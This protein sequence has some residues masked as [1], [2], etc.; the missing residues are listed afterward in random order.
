MAWLHSGWFA[1]VCV[2][3]LFWILYEGL[4]DFLYHVL[5][6]QVFSKGYGD[7]RMISLTFDDGPD[8]RYTPQVLALLKENDAKATFFLVGK[9]AKAYPDLVREIVKQGHE[10]AVHGYHHTHAWILSPWKTVREFRDTSKVLQE[11]TGQTPKYYRP[12]WGMFNLC[13]R[14]AGK[15]IGALPVL[16]NVTA[17][18]WRAGDQVD[19]IKKNILETIAPG[20]IVLLHDSGGAEGAP[21]NTLTCLRD[22]VPY[23][24]V[25]NYDLVSIGTLLAHSRDA[26]AEHAQYKQKWIQ[27]IWNLWEKLFTKLNHVRTIDQMMRLS[28]N[29]WKHEPKFDDAG[30]VLVKQGDCVAEIHFQNEYLRSI[31]SDS[32]SERAAIKVIRQFRTSLHNVALVLQHDPRYKDVQ[33]I[34]GVTLLHR[35]GLASGFHI[36]EIPDSLGKKYVQLFLRWLMILYHPAGAKRLKMRTEELVPKLVWMSRAEVIDKYL[37]VTNKRERKQKT[38]IDVS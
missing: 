28:I 15:K 6:I 34:Y 38:T 26:Q 20:A 5:R 30:N 37:N 18:D 10:I 19:A 33:A 9:K 14:I 4:P 8:P 25:L 17:Y 12:P 32:S 3:V 2:V 35:G 13:T 1:I 23:L 21:L 22:V 29:T 36:D 24:K 11:I 27:P 16:W 31:S 7:A